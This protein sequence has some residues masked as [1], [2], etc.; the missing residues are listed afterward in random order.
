MLNNTSIVNINFTKEYDIYIGRNSKWGN[1]FIIGKHGSREEVIELYRQ[2]VLGNPEL[3]NSIPELKGK[4]LGCF[5]KPAPCHGDILAKLANG[6]LPMYKKLSVGIDQSYQRTGISIAADNKLLVVRSIDFNG[7][8]TK[9]EKRKH[10]K[11]ILNKILSSNFNKANEIVI[12]VERI[13]TFSQGR[14]QNQ[15]FGLKPDYLKS[16]G[17][18]IATIV[19]TA[20]EYNVP[21]YSVDT[22]SWKSKILGNSKTDAVKYKSFEKPEKAAAILFVQN[23]GFDVAMRNKDGSLKIH[24]KGKNEGK[25]YYDDDAADSACIALY[26][27]VNKQNLKLEE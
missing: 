24:K 19:D 8:K 12:L 3:R 22:R 10:L 9:T 7:C 15:G 5:C 17:A 23:K 1:P 27:F 14:N 13:R 16:T 26:A 21:V 18:L 11:E 2:Y 25:V 4:V 6:E 20:F